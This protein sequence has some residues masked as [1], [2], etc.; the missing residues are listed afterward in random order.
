MVDARGVGDRSVSFDAARALAQETLVRLPLS[1]AA[2]AIALTGAVVASGPSGIPLSPA[3]LAVNALVILVNL[4]L[5]VTARAGKVPLAF[6][7]PAALAVWLGAPICTLAALAATHDPRL[8]LALV[9]E[10]VAAPSII[11]AGRWIGPGVVAAAAGW[12]ALALRDGGAIF[13]EQAGFVVA[14]VGLVGVGHA[15]HS[16][17]V[18]RGDALR[19]E[20]AAANARLRAELDERHRAEAERER[21][22]QE[23]I[24]AQRLEAVGTLAGGLAHDMNNILAGILGA[25]EALPGAPA[26]ELADL[27]RRIVDEAQRGAELTRS[28]LAFSRRG[29]YQ[30]KPI[31][32][33]AAIDEVVAVLGRAVPKHVTLTVHH[34][35]RDVVVDGDPAQ[36]PQVFFNLALNGVQALVAA[37]EVAIHTRLEPAGDGHAAVIEVRDTGPGMD[38]ETRAHIFEP[39]FTTKPGGRGL[40]LAMAWGTIEA[41]RGTLGVDSVVGGGTVLRVRLPARIEPARAVAAV[42][43]AAPPPS[44]RAAATPLHVLLVDDEPLIRAMYERALARA[45]MRVTGAADGAEALARFAAAAPPIDVVVLDMAMP[46]MAGGETF[47]KLREQRPGLPIVLASGYTGDAETRELVATGNA[48][49]LEKPFRVE[50]L[51]TAVQAL[52]PAP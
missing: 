15:V 19:A 26:A 25:A 3:L 37:G 7:G 40:G 44:A 41:H 6:A 18:I 17:A 13:R 33:A 35:R 42:A 46:V 9:I 48:V 51:V 12:S 30:H 11:L 32:L 22:R 28:L 4:A 29:Q 49:F 34:A 45:G 27:G 23:L 50:A 10:L 5:F 36:L 16:R 8:S 39:F 43:A 38:A 14:A 24:A 21:Y 47:R 31:A 2:V 1:A 52:R 20:I